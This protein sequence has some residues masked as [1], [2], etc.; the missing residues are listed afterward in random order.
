MTSFGSLLIMYILAHS[1]RSS[2]AAR[3]WEYSCVAHCKAALPPALPCHL[4]S[5]DEEA[6]GG[7]ERYL[8][9]STAMTRS[10]THPLKS[11]SQRVTSTSIILPSFFSCFPSTFA[12]SCIPL[13]DKSPNSG[14]AP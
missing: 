10:A 9:T 4:H 1:Y 3:S 13:Y 2:L 7:I 11:T 8:V 5:Y 14:A 6:S 12:G